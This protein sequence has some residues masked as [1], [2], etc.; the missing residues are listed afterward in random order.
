M[1][2]TAMFVAAAVLRAQDAQQNAEP[3]AQTAAAEQKA[4]NQSQH[5][6]QAQANPGI[7]RQR[8]QAE[9]QAQRSVDRDAVAAI[10]EARRAIEA[11]DQGKTDE[12]LAAIERATGKINIL[13]GRDPNAALLP[14]Q[15]EAV[16]IDAAPLDVKEIRA[17]AKAAENAVEDRDFPAARVILTGLISEIRVRTFNLPLATYPTAMQDAARLL[18]QQ[19]PAEA[20]AVLQAALNTLAIVDN[21]MPLPIVVAEEAVTQAQ[22]VRD[23]DKDRAHRLLGVARNELR[24]A[25]ELGYAGND[26]EYAA[27]NQA[28]EDLEKQLRGNQDATSAFARLKERVSSFFRRQ[29]SSQKTGQVASR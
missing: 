11:I 3:E 18:D 4:Q 8:Q 20:K 1:A 15:A 26:P 16:V 9:Q 7:E 19:K 13:V 28:I 12:A 29:A 23:Q 2:A 22:S 10:E 24:R 6:A 14:V 5:Q 17:R 27:L 21:I 25:K